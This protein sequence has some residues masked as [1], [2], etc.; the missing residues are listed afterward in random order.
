MPTERRSDANLSMWIDRALIGAVGV[1]FIYFG[2]R[3][4]ALTQKVGNLAET[5]ASVAS[6]IKFT[7]EKT[8]QLCV[9]FEKHLEDERLKELREKR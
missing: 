1:I 2:T 8:D 5:M 4:E 6:E 7:N 9:R 3:V